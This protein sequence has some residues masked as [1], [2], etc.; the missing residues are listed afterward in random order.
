MRRRQ[1]GVCLLRGVGLAGLTQKLSIDGTL[2]PKIT[3]FHISKQATS[4][5]EAISFLTCAHARPFYENAA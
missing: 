4:F 5:N 3:K 2:N 1:S